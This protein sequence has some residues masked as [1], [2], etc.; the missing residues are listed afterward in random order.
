MPY[1][2]LRAN[3]VQWVDP[4]DV[5]QH[6]LPAGPTYPVRFDGTTTTA[7]NVSDVYCATACLQGT[8]PNIV[9]PPGAHAT[10][11]IGSNHGWDFDPSNGMGTG[12]CLKSALAHE[13]VLA[14]GFQSDGDLASGE[15]T[16]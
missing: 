16:E 9:L 7:T 14:L 13:I 3:M 10:I 12:Y 5:L 15:A 11:T 2:I 8:F 6:F 1:D 4:S